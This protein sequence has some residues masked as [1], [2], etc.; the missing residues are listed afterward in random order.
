MQIH[1]GNSPISLLSGEWLGCAEAAS[2]RTVA[3]S[4]RRHNVCVLFVS[5]SDNYSL[6]LIDGECSGHEHT[7]IYGNG[8]KRERKFEKTDNTDTD[9]KEEGGGRRDERREHTRQPLPFLLL[10]LLLLILIIIVILIIIIIFFIFIFFFVSFI[11][12]LA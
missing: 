5:V 8:K 3:P 4:S 10:L 12:K 1:W 2:T 6:L 9:R 7:K 11:V